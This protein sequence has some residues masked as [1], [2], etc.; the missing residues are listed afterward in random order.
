MWANLK[1]GERH[2]RTRQ[3]DAVRLQEPDSPSRDWSELGIDPNYG[4][5][6]EF[7]AQFGEA[8]VPGAKPS[9]ISI[10]AALRESTLCTP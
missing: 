1:L 9:N 7:S 10:D 4:L 3:E 5:L 6:E 2:L 8:S